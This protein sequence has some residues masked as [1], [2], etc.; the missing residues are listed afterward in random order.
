MKNFPFLIQGVIVLLILAGCT[1]SNK[2]VQPVNSILVLQPTNNANE[3]TLVNNNGTDN[4]G[5]TIEM[6]VEAWTN[7]GAPFTIREIFKYD[8]STIPASASV[9]AADLALYSDTIPIN[10]N[11]S[12]ANYGDSNAVLVESV[13]QDWNPSTVTWFNQPTTSSTLIDT[14]P[15]TNSSFLNVDVDVTGI[16]SNMIKTNVNYGFLLKMQ[17]EITYNSRIFCSSSYSDTTRHPKL[18]VHYT[19]TP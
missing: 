12:D 14:I 2:N 18:T 17:S 10:G 7:G 16:V 5:V 15:Q 3:I 13:T 6:P 9:T 4:S 19:Y 1:K 11:L 8:L